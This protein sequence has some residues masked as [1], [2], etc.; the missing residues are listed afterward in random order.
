MYGMGRGTEVSIGVDIVEV[1]RLAHALEGQPRLAERLFTAEELRACAALPTRV[2]RLAG[3]FAA[4]E[5]VA[6]ALGAP[7]SWHEVEIDSQQGTPT[8]RLYGRAASLAA[9]KR[10]LVSIS[11]C[12][13]YA[14]AQALVLL[15]EESDP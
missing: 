14:V 8:V 3:R 13:E 15:D 2:G 5:A 1:Q 4:K 9:G 6:K 10:V 7:L 11:H 12:H